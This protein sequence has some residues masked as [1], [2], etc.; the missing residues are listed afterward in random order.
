M[1][2]Q[3]HDQN[4]D[5]QNLEELP[6]GWMLADRHD[7]PGGTFLWLVRTET[8]PARDWVTAVGRTYEEAL[9]AGWLRARLYDELE[10]Y[11][12]A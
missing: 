6:P 8:N 9:R 7:G 1:N 2:I 12:G 3:R 10:W 11:R 4:E 5:S